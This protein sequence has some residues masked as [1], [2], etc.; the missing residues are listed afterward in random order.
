MAGCMVVVVFPFILSGSFFYPLLSFND[1]MLYSSIYSI[2]T[3][4]SLTSSMPV[5]I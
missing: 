1:C 5:S 2:Y 4:Y 3:V